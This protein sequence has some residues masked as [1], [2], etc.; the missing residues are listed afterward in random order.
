MIDFHTHILP[1]VDDGSGSIRESVSMLREEARQGIEAVVLTP[2][3]YADENDIPTFLHRRQRAWNQLKAYLP[4]QAPDLY[5]GAEVQYFEGIRDA[6][7]IHLL[8]ILGSSLL[9]IEMPFCRWTDRMVEDVLELNDRE[10]LQVVLAHIER[11]ASMQPRNTWREL[12]ARGIMTQAN[13]SFFAGWKTRRKAMSMLSDGEIHFLG[14]DCHNMTTRPPNWDR[15]PQRAAALAAQ[16]WA[17]S[18]FRK[19]EGIRRSM[20]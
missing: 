18:S 8:R 9:L 14:S 7:N 15:L 13:I 3:F 5:L 4:P 2:H 17:Y 12:C 1:C 19:T 16:N 6:E 20:L 11:Y 10:N